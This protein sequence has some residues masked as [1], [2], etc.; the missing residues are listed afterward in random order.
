MSVETNPLSPAPLQTKPVETAGANKDYFGKTWGRWFIELRDKV[1]VINALI[2]EFA[3]LS[4]TGFPALDNGT[5]NIRQLEAGS[6]IDV[7]NPDGAAGNPQ[8]SLDNPQDG[9][10]YGRQD[11]NWVVVPSASIT[12]PRILSAASLRP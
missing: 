12:Y 10:I 5:W 11:D 3:D 9:Q 7:T 2:V 6:G 8:I 1:N 4:G